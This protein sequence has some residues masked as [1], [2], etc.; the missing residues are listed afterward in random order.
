MAINENCII[1]SAE[2][3]KLCVLEKKEDEEWGKAVK[4]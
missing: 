4:N 2:D 1:S 3:L